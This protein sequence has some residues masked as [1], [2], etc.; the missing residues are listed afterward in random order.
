MSLIPRNTSLVLLAGVLLA[1]PAGG[2]AGCSPATSAGSPA[3]SAAGGGESRYVSGDG[4]VRY[5]PSAQRRPAP[6]VSATTL[7]GDRLVLS[8]HRGKVLVLNVWASWCPP[9]R[10]EAPALDQVSQEVR[11]QGVRFVGINTRDTRANARAFERRFAISYPSLFDESGRIILAF[12]GQLPP[13]AIPSTL[14]L[15]RQGRV[16]ARAL[17][18]LTVGGLRDLLA[19]VLEEPS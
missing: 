11:S 6:D 8:D 18:P 14:V 16:A 4:S 9:C 13:Q 10:A 7:E 15:D 17:R 19:P 1:A 5:I 3:G 2:L 12:R